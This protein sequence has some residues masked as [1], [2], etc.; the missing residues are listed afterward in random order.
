MFPWRPR[1]RRPVRRRLCAALALA[2]YL[3]AAIGFPVSAA[4]RSDS[5]ADR[6]PAH[7]RGRPCCCG[8]AD[9]CCCSAPQAEET[10]EAAPPC[11]VGKG[12]SKHGSSAGVRWVIGVEALKCRGHATLWI[13]SGCVLPP[14]P[15]FAWAVRLDPAGPTPAADCSPVTLDSGPPTPP[16]R[17]RCL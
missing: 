2:A 7:A 14:E 9:G 4:P 17:S 16:P 13:S 3:A 12:A 11:C 8:S 15:P 6:G 10:P 1:L 5:P